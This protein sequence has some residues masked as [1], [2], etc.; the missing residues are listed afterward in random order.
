MPVL[1]LALPIA[2]AVVYLVVGQW[3]FLNATRAGYQHAL[4]TFL[5]G[6][7]ILLVTR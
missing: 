1:W 7:G 5:I 6:F 2:A 4:T 3:L